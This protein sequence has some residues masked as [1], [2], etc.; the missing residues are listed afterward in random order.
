MIALEVTGDREL[1]FRFESMGERIRAALKQS[2]LR[3]MFGLQAHVQGE[4]LSGQVLNVR[5]GRLRA[6]I[7]SRVT[8]TPTAVTG[9][10]GTNVEYAGVHEFGFSGSQNVAAFTRRTPS[11]RLA[12]V[13]AFTRQVSLPERSFLRSSLRDQASEIRDELAKGV[14]DAL[15]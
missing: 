7:T 5:T 6:S 2:M 11:G 14:A 12:N 10:V 8:E 9:I 3:A 1:R 4:K 13:R 15:R